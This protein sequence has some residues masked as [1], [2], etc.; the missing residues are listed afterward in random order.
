[1]AEL[2]KKDVATFVAREVEEKK[3]RDNYEQQFREQEF[4]SKLNLESQLAKERLER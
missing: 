2:R 1:M 3:K 4:A